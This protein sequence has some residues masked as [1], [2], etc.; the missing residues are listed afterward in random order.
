MRRGLLAALA[1]TVALGVAAAK[2]PKK[3]EVEALYEEFRGLTKGQR[4]AKACGVLRRMGK[5]G[6]GLAVRVVIGAAVRYPERADITAA[7]R[8]TLEKMETEDACKALSAAAGSF[9]DWRGRLL[10]LEA[11]IY[12]RHPVVVP[13]IRKCLG[14]RKPQV[15]RAA[16]RGV[17]AAGA[18]ELIGETIALVERLEKERGLVWLDAVRALATLLNAEA[19]DAEGWRAL[20]EAKKAEME[21]QKKRGE[22]APH[23]DKGMTVVAKVVK[24][25]PK[26]FGAEI[27]SNR[28][29]FVIDCSSSM[30]AR[31]PEMVRTPDGRMTLKRKLP[32][33]AAPDQW[34]GFP[35][36][37]AD[38]ARMER[39]KRELARCIKSLPRAAKFNVISFATDVKRWRGGLVRA[40]DG[41]KASATAWV[42]GIRA[43]GDTHTDD[44]LKEAFADA[45]V[46]TIYLLSDGQPWKDG[47][48]L[49]V[50]SILKWVADENRF[51]RITIHT[52]GFEF[53]RKA[54]TLH[55][56]DMMRFLKGLAEQNRGRF[57]N[58]YW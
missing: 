50:D 48:P 46:D 7:A 42:R 22:Y 1:V 28:V 4:W 10:A 40:S 30:Q 13:T 29:I 12:R 56:A 2:D 19:K 31:D 3:K 24:E 53:A 5:L 52:F 47:C 25:A 23:E 8:E 26:F 35:S 27:V 16:I 44:A 15:V 20:Y 41:N 33:G 11:L 34:G 37:P 17:L 39:V 38:R 55:L 9:R 43:K 21:E 51:R 57:T 49:D 45:E 18:V 36:L 6:T 54:P 14:D 32:K 58:I